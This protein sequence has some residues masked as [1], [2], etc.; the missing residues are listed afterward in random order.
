MI[1]YLD[2][3]LEF[4]D[5]TTPIVSHIYLFPNGT[6]SWQKATIP[7]LAK[8]VA[9]HNASTTLKYGKIGRREVESVKALVNNKQ[10]ISQTCG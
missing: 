1:V 6:S 5:G 3:P 7:S 8:T 10:T 9:E 2:L 4:P